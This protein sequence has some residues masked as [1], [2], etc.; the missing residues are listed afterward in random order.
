MDACMG[1]W[2]SATFQCM[3]AAALSRD[4]VES[5]A[6]PLHSSPSVVSSRSRAQSDLVLEEQRIGAGA[7]VLLAV[8][9]WS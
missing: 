3:D 6:A 4:R 2:L 5:C 8:G 1:V 7:K 9:Q